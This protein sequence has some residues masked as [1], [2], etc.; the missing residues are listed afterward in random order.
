MDDDDL[1]KAMNKEIE[2]IERN[3]TW[4]LVPRPKDKNVIGARWVFIN[5]LN[6]DGEVTKNKAILVCK[7]YSQEPGIDYGDS[8]YGKIRRCEI[9]SGICNL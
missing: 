9:T 7:G 1:V 4:S 8:S 5:K 6:E 2:Q 3:Q